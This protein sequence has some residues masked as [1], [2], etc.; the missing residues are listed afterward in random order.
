MP[1]Q[2]AIDG[3]T[4]PA[5]GTRRTFDEKESVYYEGY[6]IRYYAPP[7]DTLTARRRLIK[8]LSRRLFHHTE[9]GINTP[10][11]KLGLAREAYEREADP[12]RKRVN[13]SMLAGALFNRATDIFTAAVDLQD[14]GVT[15]SPDNELMRQ[16]GQYFQEALE[17]GVQVKHYSGEEGIDELWGE[18]FK[19]FTLPIVDFYETRYVKIAKTMRDIERVADKIVSVF[20]ADAAFDGLDPL[21]VEFAAAAKLEAETMRSDPKT[22]EVW[23]HYVACAEAVEAFV[24]LL[25]PGA[26]KFVAKRA[27]E[28]MQIVKFGKDLITYLAGAR[29]PMPKTTENY[30]LR[31]DEYAARPSAVPSGA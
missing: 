28:G 13:G 10:G 4:D 18:P 1:T 12:A 20:E 31:C 19:A 30:L 14:K 8:G 25:A 5:N 16:S 7:P 22:F 21:V 6:W 3:A 11:E 26:P 27:A 9:N 15:I 29:V 24:P 23:P 17:L 2:A